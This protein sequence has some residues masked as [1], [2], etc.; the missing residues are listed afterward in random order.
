MT[1]KIQDKYLPGYSKKSFLLYHSGGEIWFEHPE[2][3]FDREDLVLEKLNSDSLVFLK[4]SAT[5]FICFVFE[6]F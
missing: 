3:L 5:F 2:C 6:D 1:E 4:P